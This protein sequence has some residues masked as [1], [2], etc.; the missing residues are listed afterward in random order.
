[1]TDTLISPCPRCLQAV[2]L[3]LTKVQDNPTCPKCHAAIFPKEALELT[4]QT[5]WPFIKRCELSVIVDVWAPWCGPCRQFAPVLA[6]YASEQ[7]GKT[8][9][10]KLN[11]D[12]AGSLA[13]QLNI[14]SIP[15]VLLY[16]QG[17][18]MARHSGA[19]SF[20]QLA[21]WARTASVA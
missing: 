2:R 19:M 14:R 4:E 8:L 3:P 10:A 13:A 20:S 9:V 1:M 18:E 21:H 6:Q 15:T 5:Y 16:R 11:S 12:E 7:A 17:Q